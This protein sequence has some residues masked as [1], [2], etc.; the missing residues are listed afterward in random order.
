MS[1]NQQQ[2]PLP[3]TILENRNL[4]LTAPC[5]TAEGKWSS[6]YFR[7][8]KGNPRLVV[9][10][11]DP[12]D[13]V[14]YGQ[15]SVPMTPVVFETFLTAWEDAIEAEP[16]HKGIINAENF[17]KGSRQPELMH[18][19]I[20][21][22][23][24]DGVVSIMVVDVLEPNR[25][26]IKFE[27]GAPRFVEYTRNNEPLTKVELSTHFSR[28]WV[29]LLRE[30]VNQETVRTWEKPAPFNPSG[31]RGNWNNNRGGGGN[32]GNWNNN[33]GGGGGGNYNNNYNRNQNQGGGDQSQSQGGGDNFDDIPF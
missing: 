24:Q 6:L 15:I 11:N 22:K 8:Y 32:R 14:N 23:D 28:I 25:P 5:P 21:G 31:N 26:R 20:V 9:R 29:R 27:V 7:I 13:K 3:S 18:K 1:E 30:L 12:N 33:R 10:T 19:I 4:A 17:P 16:G 2:S